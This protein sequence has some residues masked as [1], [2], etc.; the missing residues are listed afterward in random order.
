MDPPFPHSKEMR[1][2]CPYRGGFNEDPSNSA[3]SVRLQGGGEIPV[4][5]RGLT[6]CDMHRKNILPASKA[7]TLLV[8]VLKLGN[9]TRG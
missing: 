7:R 6:R 1:F 2:R 8:Q 9:V 5:T 3:K 4:C